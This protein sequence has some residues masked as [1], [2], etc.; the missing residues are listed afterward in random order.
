[1]PVRVV[2]HDCLSR[3]NYRDMRRVYD[4]NTRDMS[5]PGPR[6]KW[7]DFNTI[8]RPTVWHSWCS[9]PSMD[10]KGGLKCDGSNGSSRAS[11]GVGFHWAMCSEHMWCLTIEFV[12]DVHSS[13]SMYCCML[14]GCPTSNCLASQHYELLFNNK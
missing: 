3:S 7:L 11:G 1:M 2:R 14:A 6:C 4:S 12:H 13:H 8:W 10:L 5:R 9:R